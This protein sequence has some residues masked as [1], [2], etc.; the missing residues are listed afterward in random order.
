M[1]VMQNANVL[2]CMIKL[3]L[4]NQLIQLL[5]RNNSDVS[6]YSRDNL[7]LSWNDFIINGLVKLAN[8]ID[9]QATNKL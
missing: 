2:I 1:I 9:T 4:V 5:K 6:E 7:R 3:Y 8:L